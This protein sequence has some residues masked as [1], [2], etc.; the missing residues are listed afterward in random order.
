MARRVVFLLGMLSVN[1]FVFYVLILFMSP[2][3]T[4]FQNTALAFCWVF[5]CTCITFRAV[6]TNKG[7]W[8]PPGDHETD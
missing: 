8:S 2:L 5:S 3:A 7:G 1:R 4:R 6:G